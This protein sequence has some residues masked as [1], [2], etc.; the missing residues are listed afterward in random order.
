M[1]RQVSA[2]LQRRPFTADAVLAVAVEA[3]L[4]MKRFCPAAMSA[5]S[6]ISAGGSAN[7][8]VAHTSR[9][10]AALYRVGQPKDLIDA[11][12]LEM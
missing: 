10:A 2:V 12:P 1:R 4:V 8:V 7:A 5:G 6:L 11:T 3:S 9:R